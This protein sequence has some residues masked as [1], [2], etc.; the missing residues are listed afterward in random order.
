MN[1]SNSKLF[2]RGGQIAF[3]N[4]RMFIQINKALWKTVFVL[5]VVAIIGLTYFLTPKE[6]LITFYEY[7]KASMLGWFD[8][9][10]NLSIPIQGKSVAINSKALLS[11]PYFAK[12][13]SMLWLSVYKAF[14]WS[15]VL[16]ITGFVALVMFFVFKGKKQGESKFLRGSSI[17]A[18]LE[19]ARLINRDK[20]ASDLVIDG[21]PILKNS[22]VQHFLIHGTIGTG[23]SQL[24]MKFFLR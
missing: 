7:Q 3:H 14:I 12:K 1:D 4:L 5:M 19:L 8:V 10:Y 9:Y 13:A 2:T 22:E 18:P 21:V 11:H 24:M 16:T 17:A 20:M 15:I 6:I 23:K